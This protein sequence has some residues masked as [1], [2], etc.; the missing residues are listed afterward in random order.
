MISWRVMSH[1]AK[2]ER[3]NGTY[4]EGLRIPVLDLFDGRHLAESIGQL[5]QILDS[6]C[7]ANGELLGEELRCAEEGAW[8]FIS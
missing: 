2:I 7:Q 3:T 1:R 6:M 8:T 5:A 4:L